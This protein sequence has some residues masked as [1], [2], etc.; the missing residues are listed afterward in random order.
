MR[1]FYLFGLLIG[2]FAFAK[3]QKDSIRLGLPL[4]HAFSVLK[5]SFAANGKVIMTTSPDASIKIWETSTGRLIQSIDSLGIYPSGA[6]SHDGRH[7][8]SSSLPFPGFLLEKGSLSSWEVITGRQKKLGKVWERPLH[9]IIDLLTKSK[10]ALQQNF[11]GLIS[12]DDFSRVAAI[13]V[14][15]SDNDFTFCTWSIKSGYFQRRFKG[16]K[17]KIN[18]LAFSPNSKDILTSSE[19]STATL[20]N[21]KSGKVKHRLIGHKGNVNTAVYNHDGKYIVTASDDKTIKKWDATTGKLVFSIEGHQAPISKAIFTSTGKKIITTSKDRTIKVWD[22]FNGTLLH[23]QDK[24]HGDVSLLATGL[25]SNAI[26]YVCGDSIAYVYDDRSGRIIHILRGH[27][28]KINSISLSPDG[29]KLLTASDDRTARIWDLY[30]GSSIKVLQ[31]AMHSVGFEIKTS[32][33]KTTI[34]TRSG[35]GKTILIWDSDMLN[36]FISLTDS[37]RTFNLFELSPDGK[38]LATTYARDENVNVWNAKTGDLLY[39]LKQY[40]RIN[41]VAFDSDSKRLVTTSEDYSA[42]V[43]DLTTGKQLSLIVASADLGPFKQGLFSPDNEYLLTISHKGAFAW[44]I[45]T[46]T[47]KFELDK[48]GIGTFALKEFFFTDSLIACDENTTGKRYYWNASDGSRVYINHTAKSKSHNFPPPSEH[49]RTSSRTHTDE[50]TVPYKGNSIDHMI[51]SALFGDATTKRINLKVSNS[52]DRHSVLFSSSKGRALFKISFPTND[53]PVY[54]CS[55]G[56]YM[57]SL[58]AA[59]KLYYIRGLQTIGFDQLDVKYNRPDKVLSA[60]GEA[61]GNPDTALI[62]SYYR[63]WQKRVKKLGV[64]TTSFEEGFSVPESDFKNRDNIQYEQTSADG[65][66]QLKV[67]GMDTTYKLDRYNI[68]VNDVPI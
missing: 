36:S 53:S 41:S 37:Q 16:H 31:S 68:W 19:D 57:A 23:S 11:E 2:C 18:T 51:E 38:Y 21:A 20:W 4:G 33:S 1:K 22:A 61:F 14:S 12:S 56:H 67:W 44:D 42:I 26:V 39:A 63:A 49:I 9:K 59:S 34:A 35:T 52:L 30:T 13:P 6:I 5:A 62:N 58:K 8:I 46:D 47:Q 28:N 54:S 25:D 50:H 7:I 64:D 45:A 40:G 32:D 66:L 43:W 24:L 48:D 60:L 55:S 17:G 65:K 27:T 29:L 15:I 3:A 10:G